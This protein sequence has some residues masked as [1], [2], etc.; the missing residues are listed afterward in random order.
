M[1]SAYAKTKTFSINSY[2]R[3][4]N[5]VEQENEFMRTRLTDNII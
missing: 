5:K 3:D 1:V 2:S 4:N